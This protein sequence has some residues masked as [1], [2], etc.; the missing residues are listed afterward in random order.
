[1]EKNNKLKKIKDDTLFLVQTI[2]NDFAYLEWKK[3]I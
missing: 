1:M 2:K 3:I